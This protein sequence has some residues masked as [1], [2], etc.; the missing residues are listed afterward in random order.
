MEGLLSTGPT[1]SSLDLGGE[2]GE[3]LARFRLNNDL[4]ICYFVIESIRIYFSLNLFSVLIV[5]LFFMNIN[6]IKKN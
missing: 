3:K 2:S 1:P 4:L 6:Q 5:I